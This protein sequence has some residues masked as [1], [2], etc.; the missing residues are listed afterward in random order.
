[1]IGW[2]GENTSRR[3]DESS[4]P[5][6]LLLP[7]GLALGWIVVHDRRGRLGLIRLSARGSLVV[8]YVVV[9]GL[10]LVISELASIGQHLTPGVV[11][12][13]W[14]AVAIGLLTALGGR[15]ELTGRMGVVAAGW[16]GAS[17]AERIAA[18]IGVAYLGFLA[19]IAALYHPATADSMMYHLVRVEHWIQDRSVSPYATHQ[20]AQ[21][22]LSPLHEYWLTQLHLLTGIDRVDGFVELLAYV[23]CAAA[24]SEV[25]RLLGGSRRAQVLAPALAVTVPVAILEATST[26]NDLFGAAIGLCGIVVVLSWQTTGALLFRSALLGLCGGLAVL[27]KGNVVPM[28][29]PALLGLGWLAARDEIRRHGR[30]GCTRLARAA[31]VALVVSA[32]AA[33]PFVARNHALFG[34]VI[35]ADQD[36]LRVKEVTMASA[37]ANTVRSIA[38]NFRTGHDG[39]GPEHLLG[40]VALGVG[41][42]AFDV[43]GV[44]P[45]DHRYVLGD[46]VDVFA[47]RDH[48]GYQLWAEHG[49]NPWHVVLLSASGVILAVSF[50]RR[51]TDARVVVLMLGLATGFVLFASLVRWQTFGVRFQLPALVAWCPLIALALDRFGAVAAR[52]V[53]GLLVVASLPMLLRNGER[54]LIRPTFDDAR[55][56]LQHY[57]PEGSGAPTSAAD[58]DAVAAALAAS[59]CQ[60]L[61]MTNWVRFEYPLWMALRHRQWEGEIRAT[62]VRNESAKLLDDD[63]EPCAT[64]RS[65][66]LGHASPALGAGQSRFGE[67]LLTLEQN[68]GPQ[69]G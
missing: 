58:Y 5:M 29:G 40:V 6:F 2:P 21:I 10:V 62:E 7:L 55:F 36:Q 65:V 41:A 37:G 15:L 34:S 67:L 28:V 46:E 60:A 19:V 38:A 59:G 50:V 43:F 11:A 53:V 47:R 66:P 64:V 17:L 9:N 63:F 31:G 35:G 52:M 24:V 54:P 26:Q 69:A 8:A 14:L 3:R 18:W 44:A 57:V 13:A 20:L 22:D 4:L 25:A 30:A 68:R 56:Y 39:T 23:V 27:A 48:S 12:V 42:R 1:M 49:A 33:G 32:V 61:G 45:E 16:R 51:R